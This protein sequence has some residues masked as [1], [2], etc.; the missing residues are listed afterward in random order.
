MNDQV[1]PVT[2]EV[3]IVERT[4]GDLTES[5]LTVDQV[6]SRLGVVQEIIERVFVEGVH[7]GTVP[8]T[9]RP[10]L[11][12]PGSEILCLTFGLHPKFDIERIDL[13]NNHR[14]YILK[15]DL[16]TRDG[17]FVAAGVASCSTLEA[18]Y[19][20]RSAKKKCPKCNS[21]SIIKG[22]KEYGGG[23]VCFAKQGGCGAKFNDGDKSI[24][25]QVTGRIEN[26]DIADQYNTVL[27]M[28]KKRALSDAILTAT[29]C[30]NRF[31]QDLEENAPTPPPRPT[32]KQPAQSSPPPQE[33]KLPS[34]FYDPSTM[35][36]YVDVC[37]SMNYPVAESKEAKRSEY[38]SR[39]S[40]FVDLMRQAADNYS[41]VDDLNKSGAT[42]FFQRMINVLSQQ[43]SQEPSLL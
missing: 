40:A 41:E 36:A 9:D 4:S 24:E 26:I 5:H 28:G 3:T 11:Y 17:S 6:L 15:C 20:W 32:P 42:T 23:W 25:G 34:V 14:E 43:E 35:K 31:T 37:K 33:S 16:Y 7:Y 1:N 10:T 22:K 2:G 13:P 21:E 8:G 12:K 29:G 18:K 39:I 27:K 30:S 19:R 38:E